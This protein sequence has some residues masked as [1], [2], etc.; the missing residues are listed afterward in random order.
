MRQKGPKTLDA[1]W[2]MLQRTGPRLCGETCPVLERKSWNFGNNSRPRRDFYLRWSKNVLCPDKNLRAG[3]ET[4]YR[5]PA[6]T[7]DQRF[8]PSLL[9][10][11]PA[12]A[13]AVFSE[14]AV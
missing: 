11:P 10:K 8:R 7:G 13:R 2:R 1:K 14:G 12:G 5:R 9:L 6:P 4:H 3:A